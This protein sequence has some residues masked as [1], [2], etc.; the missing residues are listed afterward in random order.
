MNK[1]LLKS[2]FTVSLLVVLM[3]VPVYG[4]DVN[5]SRNLEPGGRSDG[6]STVNGSIT[7][8]DGAT[9]TGDLET[10]NGRIQVGDKSSFEDANTVNGGLTIGDSVSCASLSTVNG[11]IEV[12]EQATAEEISSVNGH[13]GLNKGS[14]TRGDVSNVNGGVDLIGSRIGGDLTTVNGNVDLS[15]GA[16]VAGDLVVKKPHMWSSSD[17]HLPEIV[18]G[19]GSRVEGTIRLER[20]VKLY[21][22]ETAQIGA[23]EGVM[24][25]DDAIRFSG[26]RP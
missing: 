11:T 15:D 10:V 6:E 17:S 26:K 20:K 8:G 9:V 5:K 21:V 4:A 12:G 22:S 1:V 24:S 25:M 18:I 14:S 3:A 19:P 16:V 7:V 23:V 2:A 13:I